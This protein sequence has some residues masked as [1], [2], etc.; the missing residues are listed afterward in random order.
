VVYSFEYDS[1]G[2]PRKAKVSGA[3]SFMES[4]STYTA[5]GAYA[6]TITDSS[7]NSVSYAYNESKGTL[8]ASQTL[9]GRQQPTAMTAILMRL[10]GYLRRLTE[11]L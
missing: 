3:T 1:Y 10:P 6:D 9:R 8:Q 5:S 7:G 11:A 2:N 4:S